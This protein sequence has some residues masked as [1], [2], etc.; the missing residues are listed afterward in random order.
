MNT[1]SVYVLPAAPALEFTIKGEPEHFQVEELPG[2]AASGSGEHLHLWVEKVGMS[3][4]E[5]VRVLSRGLH[6][7]TSDFGWCGRKDRQAL[8]RQWISVRGARE[9]DLERLHSTKVRVLAWKRDGRKLRLGEHAGNR[10]RLWLA[11]LQPGAAGVLE[12]HREAFERT[13]LPNFYGEQRYGAAG[14]NP[15]LARAWLLGETREFLRLYLEPP[16]QE[17]AVGA[18]L[19]P[20]LASAEAADWRRAKGLLGELPRSVH[21]VAEQMAR[22]PLDEDSLLRAV[23]REE[24]RLFSDALQGA[25]FDRWLAHR[26]QEHADW[27]APRFGD[28][29]GGPGLRPHFVSDEYPTR[30]EEQLLGPL[31]GSDLPPRGHGSTG[32]EWADATA[33]GF[34]PEF[35]LSA[36][37]RAPRGARR[38]AVA[39][40][41]EWSV[42][43]GEGG[44]WLGFALPPGAYATT[45]LAQLGKDFA[46]PALGAAR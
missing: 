23:P 1:N 32:S 36:G 4:L 40:V 16:H 15:A 31:F 45:V 46:L 19:G 20:L 6:R 22:R 39:A 44:C 14:L 41:S 13:G 38:E 9:E 21:W 3:T 27:S 26:M 34:G 42:E 24:A 37:E 8:T 18:A 28:C 25:L 29:V 30:P 7:R 43:W 35:W 11:G 5:A 12:D 10:F 2:R 17:P 33:L